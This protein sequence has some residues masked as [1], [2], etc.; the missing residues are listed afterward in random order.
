[1]TIRKLSLAAL[2]AVITPFVACS[3][4]WG[5]FEPRDGGSGG[6]QGSGGAHGIGGTATTG[7][8]GGTANTGGA[9]GT[10]GTG[11]GPCV[12]VDGGQDHDC[13]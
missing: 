9:G 12:P 11:G 10:V 2:L 6:V 5:D 13:G 8:A 3:T 7:G 4:R 1:M